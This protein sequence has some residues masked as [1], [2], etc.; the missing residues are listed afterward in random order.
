M[1]TVFTKVMKESPLLRVKP[2]TEVLGSM[3]FAFT[4]TSGTCRFTCF[5]CCQGPNLM[6]EVSFLRASQNIICGVS[7]YLMWCVSFHK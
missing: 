2:M 3:A 5:S 4:F 7:E 6:H 1:G